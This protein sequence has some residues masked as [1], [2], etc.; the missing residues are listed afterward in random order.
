M[1]KTERGQ[2]TPEDIKRFDAVV[3]RSKRLEDLME[4]MSLPAKELARSE[5]ALAKHKNDAALL[6]RSVQVLDELA[7]SEQYSDDRVAEIRSDVAAQQEALRVA[8][9]DAEIRAESMRDLMLPHLIE[10]TALRGDKE[11]TRSVLQDAYEDEMERCEEHIEANNQ[12]F[13]EYDIKRDEEGV[14]YFATLGRIK[15][16]RPPGLKNFDWRLGSDEHPFNNDIDELKKIIEQQKTSLASKYADAESREIGMGTVSVS[17]KELLNGK[18]EKE[19]MAEIVALQTELSELK[20][21]KPL[22]GSLFEKGVKWKEDV[23]NKE[24]QINS[25]KSQLERIRT[26]MVKEE[27]ADAILQQE[28][29]ANDKIMNSLTELLRLRTEAKT[30]QKNMEELDRKLGLSTRDHTQAKYRRQAEKDKFKKMAVALGVELNEP[31]E[32]AKA[33]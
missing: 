17:V 25:R 19:E 13:R 3:E 14:K 4:K 15:A 33:A 23:R 28:K 9:M 22:F 21:N 6:D 30:H 24:G 20:R 7:S 11:E 32:E 8:I 12:A 18:L 2:R 1:N 27:K 29:L 5:A 26:R 31:S 16:A 10:Q